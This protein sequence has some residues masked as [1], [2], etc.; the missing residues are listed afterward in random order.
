VS[1]NPD[2][3]AFVDIGDGLGSDAG[4]TR[5]PDAAWDGGSGGVGG[6]AGVG[7][8]GSPSDAAG[9]E[10]GPAPPVDAAVTA[11][12]SA[13][14]PDTGSPADATVPARDSPPPPRP[15]AGPDSSNPYMGSTPLVVTRP[16]TPATDMAEYNFETGTQGWKDIRHGYYKVREIPV[17]PTT[18]RFA[19]KGG[20]KI[21]LDLTM[22]PAILG[23]P[24]EQYQR[25]IG[26]FRNFGS[27]LPPGRV[28]TMRFWFPT[29][30][31]SYVQPFVIYDDTSG[32]SRWF[33]NRQ[34]DVYFASS[35][36][37]GEWN[38][39]TVVV[40]SDSRE[41]TQLGMQWATEG[42]RNVTV[43]MDSI[44]F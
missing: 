38:T 44:D 35:L 34:G 23:F 24:N 33:S 22:A 15:D 1:P 21:S 36:R 2:Y 19:G 14:P 30:G 25:Y 11:E 4:S 20:I 26:I 32:R 9:A 42:A 39:L 18:E 7:A 10:A 37:P 28:V 41:V 27:A 16:E 6:G 29:G 8:G 17:E 13:P 12:T 43:Y 40:P 31:I 3:K 5:R